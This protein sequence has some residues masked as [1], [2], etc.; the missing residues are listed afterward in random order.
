M[1][2][3]KIKVEN[4]EH[5]VELMKQGYNLHVIG[6]AKK[7]DKELLKEGLELSSTGVWAYPKPTRFR[8]SAREKSYR[9]SLLGDV[10]SNNPS[11][12]DN[13]FDPY[14][15]VISEIADNWARVYTTKMLEDLA[16]QSRK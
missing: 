2:T 7:L 8:L 13:T 4:F 6:I 15:W 16:E 11:L 1:E 9:T 5:G 14:A 12:F 3:E 10:L